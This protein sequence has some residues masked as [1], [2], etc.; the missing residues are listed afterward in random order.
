MKACRFIDQLTHL[1]L[2]GGHLCGVGGSCACKAARGIVLAKN[3]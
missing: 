1:V 2:V 3:E